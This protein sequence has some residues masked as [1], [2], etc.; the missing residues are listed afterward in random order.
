M[1][2]HVGR[3]PTDTMIPWYLP[4]GVPLASVSDS[5]AAVTGACPGV[6]MIVSNGTPSR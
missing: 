4:S 6:V 2:V 5:V 1:V 3:L